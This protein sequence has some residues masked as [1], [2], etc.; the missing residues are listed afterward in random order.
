VS[1]EQSFWTKVDRSGNGCWLYCRVDELGYGRFDKSGPMA[2]AHRTAWIFTNGPIPEGMDVCHTCDV[3]NC[4][5]PAHL[6]IGTAKDNMADMIAKGRDRSRGER[7]WHAKLTEAQAL[8]ILRDKPR[9]KA[10]KARAAE[11]GVRVN[12]IESI[13]ARRSWKHLDACFDIHRED[14]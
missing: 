2:F 13:I 5:N 4:V 9:G 1:K 3:R 12:T 14:S 10:A 6:F 11:L 8:A 7:G